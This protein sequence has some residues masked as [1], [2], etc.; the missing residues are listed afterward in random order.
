MVPTVTNPVL[1]VGSTTCGKGDRYR[2]DVVPRCG[3]YCT[4][5]VPFGNW[6]PCPAFSATVRVA[7]LQYCR[8]ERDRHGRGVP[9]AEIVSAR[10]DQFETGGLVH[11]SARRFVWLVDSMTGWTVTATGRDGG[12]KC[13]NYCTLTVP[14][15]NLRPCPSFGVTVSVASR[16]NDGLDGDS[17]GRGGVSKCVSY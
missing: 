1:R 16:H 6:R 15:G 4:E 17:H 11:I 7:S 9:I 10:P 13:G 8:L 3:K 14:I 12:P 2:T 5:T